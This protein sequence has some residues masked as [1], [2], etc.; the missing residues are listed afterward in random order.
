MKRLIIIAASLLW[1]AALFAQQA[2]GPGSGIVSP[3][4]NP[5]NTVTFRYY[6]PKAVTVQVSGDFLPTQKISF[7]I[8]DKEM[9]YDAPGKADLKEVNGLW[10]YTTAPLA[11]EL[12][13]YTL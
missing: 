10:T 8:G 5:D 13:S 11:G 2:L 1:G 9:T 7:K 4:I 6:N 3:E 12:Y